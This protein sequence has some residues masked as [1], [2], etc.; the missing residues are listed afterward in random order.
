RWTFKYAHFGNYYTIKSEDSTTEYYMGVLG[1][2]TSADVNVVMRQGLDSNGTRTMSDGMLWSV[3]NTASGAYKIQAI[4]GEA[5][6]LALCVGAYVFNSNGVDNE[7]RY[8]G[9][10]SDYKDEWYLIR[11]EAPECSIFISGKVETRTFSIQ[12]I[13]TLATG[14]TWYPLI[15]ASANSWNSS[16]AGT[17]ITVNTASSSYTCE[18]V[19]YTGT[20]YGKT[21]YSVSG[22]KITDATIE[23]NSRMCLDDNTR[24]ST[25]A[26]EIGHLLGLDDNPPISNDQSLMNHERNRNTV[27]TPQ[28]FDVVNVI[29]IYSLD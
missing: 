20:W 21:S 10:D 14:A 25:I 26:H 27:Y 6:D 3:S 16:G 9:N 24:K 29:Y 22:G 1:D 19:F 7:Q 15:Q 2:S 18:V 8:Y 17:N 23:I 13:G 12:C 5:S 11:P 28:P 4:T